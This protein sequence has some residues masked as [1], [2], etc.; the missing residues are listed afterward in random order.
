MDFFSKLKKLI[1]N[2]K[3]HINKDGDIIYYYIQKTGYSYVGNNKNLSEFCRDTG[4]S[5]DD[6]INLYEWLEIDDIGSD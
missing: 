1:E 2:D 4:M 3:V 5:V 6:Q